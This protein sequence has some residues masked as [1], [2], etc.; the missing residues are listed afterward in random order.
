M[1]ATSPT[2]GALRVRARAAGRSY[3]EGYRVVDHRDLAPSH[4]Y[5]DATVEL[6]PVDV[7]IAPGLRVGYVMGVGDEVPA[8]IAQ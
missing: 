7:T 2:R 3:G 4:L 6:V 8:A 5:E 1:A